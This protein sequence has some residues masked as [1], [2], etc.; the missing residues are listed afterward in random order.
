MSEYYKTQKNAPTAPKTPIGQRTS[1][2]F[3]ITKAQINLS[4]RRLWGLLKDRAQTASLVN[5]SINGLQALI[6]EPLNP[7]DTYNTHLFIPGFSNSMNMKTKVIWCKFFR[8]ELN[9]TYYRVGF[10]FIKL[11]RKIENN[12]KKLESVS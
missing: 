1:I 3:P 2:R 11:S 7:G 10:K 5:L 9:K 6:T 8:K 4:Q 12:L